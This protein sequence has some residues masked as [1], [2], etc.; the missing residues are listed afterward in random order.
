M[1]ATLM[2]TTTLHS[3]LWTFL[4][5]TRDNA[6]SATPS[7]CSDQAGSGALP[8]SVTSVF[9]FRSSCGLR[10]L[11][12][13]TSAFACTLSCFSDQAVSGALSESVTSVFS[14]RPADFVGTLSPLRPLLFRA[15]QNSSPVT[16]PGG[17]L[18]TYIANTFFAP[19]LRPRLVMRPQ[20]IRRQVH[21]SATRR[22]TLCMS[23]RDVAHSSPVWCT[24]EGMAA[25]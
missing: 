8:K 22:H 6:T 3:I 18:G 21:R 1:T 5:M 2:V 25:P 24:L 15:F 12:N 23:V 10:T 17:I 19:P 7:C 9:F 4:K 11:Y 13:A 14:G 16:P 20:D